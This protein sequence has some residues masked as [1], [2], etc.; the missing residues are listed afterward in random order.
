MLV[1]IFRRL[2]AQRGDVALIVAGDGPY[3]EQ[4]KR[5]LANVP[6]HF[7][8]VQ[9]DAQLARLYASS[10]LFIF[11]SRTDTLG[12]AVMEAQACGLPAIVTSEGGP[13]ET[14]VDDLT[15]RVLTS[16]YIG[17]WCD[18]ISTLLDEEPRRPRVSLAAIARWGS[19][20]LSRSFELFGAEH[21]QAVQPPQNGGNS[22]K[23]VVDI[24][25]ATDRASKEPA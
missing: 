1:Q 4:M 6:A 10:D 13:K 15:G 19:F 5:E 17:D 20:C 3:L 2:A 11:P 18:A 12:Q 23:I 21:V 24:P 22:R 14:V 8:G 9:N 16:T 7:L 25:I